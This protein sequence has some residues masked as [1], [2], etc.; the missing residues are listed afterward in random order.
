MDNI[1]KM[2]DKAYENVREALAYDPE[3][4]IREKIVNDSWIVTIEKLGTGR[5]CYIYNKKTGYRH[6]NYFRPISVCSDDASAEVKA[7][8]QKNEDGIFD[9]VCDLAGKWKKKEK[10]DEEQ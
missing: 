6:Y 7:F 10:S 5:G 8:Y 4:V 3:R 2:R 1:S 9:F